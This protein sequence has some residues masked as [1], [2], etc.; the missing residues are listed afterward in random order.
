M[1]FPFSVGLKGHSFITDTRIFSVFPEFSRQRCYKQPEKNRGVQQ[2]DEQNCKHQ[3]QFVFVHNQP[4]KIS[5][6][7][8]SKTAANDRKMKM[9][10]VRNTVLNNNSSF[11]LS[12]INLRP[13]KPA[14]L[15]RQ[16]QRAPVSSIYAL[17]GL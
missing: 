14:Q 10:V 7:N 4:P 12:I 3:L 13:T 16:G 1:S 6:R 15:R 2:N 5:A 9:L 11:S 17:P 8:P